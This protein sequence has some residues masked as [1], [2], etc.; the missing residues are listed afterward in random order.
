M[1]PSLEKVRL[2]S[3]LTLSSAMHGLSSL[4]WLVSYFCSEK[5]SFCG[6][7]RF[8]HTNAFSCPTFIIRARLFMITKMSVFSE[9]HVFTKTSSFC[10]RWRYMHFRRI[11]GVCRV[12]ED[13]V[14]SKASIEPSAGD[15][16]YLAGQCHC[17]ATLAM[18]APPC[19]PAVILLCCQA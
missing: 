15:V 12:T 14:R 2:C 5:K 9:I 16:I 8:S 11:D 18:P 4:I 10:S 17:P 6:G 19:H 13:P 1:F 3:R 7:F